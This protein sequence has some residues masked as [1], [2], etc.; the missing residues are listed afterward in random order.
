METV[1]CA[2]A[3]LANKIYVLGGSYALSADTSTPSRLPISGPK[4]SNKS[5][6]LARAIAD[7][8][9]RACNSTGFR[10]VASHQRRLSTVAQSASPRS[11]RAVLPASHLAVSSGLCIRSALLSSTYHPPVTLLVVQILPFLREHDQSHLS[12]HVVYDRQIE[13]AHL[14]TQQVAGSSGAGSS[15]ECL[16]SSSCLAGQTTLFNSSWQ[17]GASCAPRW[18]SQTQSYSRSRDLFETTG[19]K[20]LLFALTRKDHV[21]WYSS[22]RL[23]AWAAVVRLSSQEAALRTAHARAQQNEHKAQVYRDYCQVA[24]HKYD[25]LWQGVAASTRQLRERSSRLTIE[26][27][28]LDLLKRQPSV[29]AVTLAGAPRGERAQ[30]GQ[31]SAEWQER[32]TVAGAKLAQV[33]QESQRL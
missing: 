9:V 25:E 19:T 6:L 13:Y 31:G 3:S 18:E 11:S 5:A 33:Q 30:A 1:G 14:S 8:S 29:Q 7:M 24:K 16:R 27:C 32:A 4:N 10:V 15:A 26:A 20:L 2:A 22:T 23:Q 21:V 17:L 28:A 12:K